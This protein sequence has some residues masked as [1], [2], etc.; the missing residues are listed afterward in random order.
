[1]A[2]P[3][4]LLGSSATDRDLTGINPFNDD[5]LSARDRAA[6]SVKASE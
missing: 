6:S 2:P 4:P 5:L 3:A 1:M